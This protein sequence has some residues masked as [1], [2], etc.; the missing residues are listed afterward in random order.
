MGGEDQWG[1]P[2]C[3]GY[4]ETPACWEFT[5]LAFHWGGLKGP[6][7]RPGVGLYLSATVSA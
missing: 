5:I 1:A 6:E 2:D 7:T 4:G 3:D